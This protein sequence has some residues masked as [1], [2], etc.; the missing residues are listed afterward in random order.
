MRANLMKAVAVLATTSALT[1]GGVAYASPGGNSAPVKH[2]Q[3][4]VKA[5]ESTQALDTDNIQSGDQ[6]TADTGSGAEAAAAES[7][8]G[9][10]SAGSEVAGND[11]PGG[12]ADE[13]GDSNAN[14]QFQ[15]Q[16]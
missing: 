12:H 14:H 11:G 13:P 2:A 4:T 10:E 3:A 5:A 9:S 7:G 1:A 16:E 8:S 15:G 6:T